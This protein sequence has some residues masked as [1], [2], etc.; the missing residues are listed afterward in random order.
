MPPN[1]RAA[2]AALPKEAIRQLRKFSKI[3]NRLYFWH[4]AW[5][6]F[7]AVTVSLVPFDAVE[8]IS[9]LRWLPDLMAGFAP[10][11][12][13][14]I[15]GFFVRFPWLSVALIL[16][17]LVIRRAS[18]LVKAAEGEYAFQAWRRTSAAGLHM[19]TTGMPKVGILVRFIQCLSPLVWVVGA[20]FVLL[21]FSDWFCLPTQT[22]DRPCTIST[23]ADT[24]GGSANTYNLHRLAPGEKMQVTIR[25]DQ[26]RNETGLWLEKDVLYTA[27]HMGSCDWR[28]KERA[29]EPHGFSFEKNCIE[30]PR[31]WWMQWIRPYPKGHWFQVVGRIDR[32][33]NVFPIFCTEGVQPSVFK[34]PADGELVLL[35][36]DV[37]YRN[38]HGVM[39]IEICRCH[40]DEPG[41]P[42]CPLESTEPD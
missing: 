4:L 3:R 11:L 1:V 8:P 14:Y 22:P 9:C 29:A 39:T 7:S 40:V 24:S 33:H 10:G 37:I 23:A 13:V 21:I 25:S 5:V 34:S 2:S 41:R 28:D 27:R 20:G 32:D 30:L 19:L 42:T 31:F 36:N 6:L 15:A 35:V 26:E 38:N 17:Y 16:L 18:A 12:P